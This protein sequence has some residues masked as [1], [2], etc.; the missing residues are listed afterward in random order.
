MAIDYHTAVSRARKLVAVYSP[1]A[2]TLHRLGLAGFNATESSSLRQ[3]FVAYSNHIQG[4]MVF[5]RL[6]LGKPSPCHGIRMG[7]A[8]CIFRL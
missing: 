8:L 7:A 2:R 5:A 4:G 6:A 1:D 3:A